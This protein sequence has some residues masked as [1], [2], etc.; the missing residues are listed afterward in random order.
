MSETADRKHNDRRGQGR[1]GTYQARHDLVYEDE[2]CE[3]CD[4]IIASVETLGTCDFYRI[5]K[6]LYVRTVGTALKL[7]LNNDT[8]SSSY[9]S[10]LVGP[11]DDLYGGLGPKTHKPVD[12]VLP[13]RGGAR[14]KFSLSKCGHP[15]DA[16]KLT[17]GPPKMERASDSG[18]VSTVSFPSGMSVSRLT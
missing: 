2:V 16:A 6:W 12:Q 17:C 7:F 5:E 13:R 11:T 1:A 18:R 10:A 15:P 8:T 9:F 4:S 3:V 14:V